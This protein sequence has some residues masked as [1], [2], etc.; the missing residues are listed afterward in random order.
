ME[1]LKARTYRSRRQNLIDRNNEYEFKYNSEN[2][3]KEISALVIRNLEHIHK[4]YLRWK[5]AKNS[6][7]INNLKDPESIWLHWLHFD[8]Q[9]YN[10]QLQG[11]PAR[12]SNDN[13]KLILKKIKSDEEFWTSVN[14]FEGINCIAWR[15]RFT[16]N[17]KVKLMK[18]PHQ[19][20]VSALHRII[21]YACGNLNMDKYDQNQKY[22]V[23]LKQGPCKNMIFF[24]GRLDDNAILLFCTEINRVP[25]T[26]DG[27]LTAFYHVHHMKVIDLCKNDEETWASIEKYLKK[28]KKFVDSYVEDVE[29]PSTYKKTTIESN[30]RKVGSSYLPFPEMKEYLND[31]QLKA[32]I[33][34]PSLKRWTISKDAKLEEINSYDK[35]LSL[36]QKLSSKDAGKSFVEILKTI[37]KFSLRLTHQQNKAIQRA[38]HVVILGR[39]GTGKTTS[40]VLR[41]FASEI[42][43]KYKIRPKVQPF[44][45]DDLK[46]TTPLHCIF[47]TASPVLTHEVKR[48]Y[49]KIKKHLSDELQ[50]R[51]N[52][53]KAAE[54]KFEVVGDDLDDLDEEGQGDFED[55][56]S[57]DDDNGPFSMKDLKDDEFPLFY[58]FRRL[59]MMID[60]SI[61]IPFFPRDVYGQIIG[62]GQNSDWTKEYLS[63]MK[64][65]KS[66]NQKYDLDSSTSSSDD[67]N[68]NES[69]ITEEIL[70]KFEKIKEHR[71]KKRN[72]EVD[73]KVFKE[74]FWPR[75]KLRTHLSPLVIWTEIN[76]YIKGSSIAWYYGGYLP[77][78]TYANRGHKIT[79]LSRDDLLKIWD[80]FYEYE[81]WKN[82]VGAYDFQDVI[83][84][85]LRSVKYNGYSGVP[86]HYM[87]ADEVQDLTHAS[88]TLLL[89]I[90]K[91]QIVFSGDTAQTIAKGSGF[92][93]SDLKNLFEE[94]HLNAPI[95]NQLTVNF[96]TH[97][98]VLGLANSVVSLLE[99]L[100]PQ[101]IDSMVRETSYRDG[102]MPLIVPSSNVE[103]LVK[104]V[105]GMD[106]KDKDEIQFGCNQVIIVRNQESKARIPAF[107]SHALCLTVFES[108]GLEFEDVILFNFFTDSELGLEK[109]KILQKIMKVEKLDDPADPLNY[110]NP[111]GPKPPI[112]INPSGP[113]NPSNPSDP[114]EPSNPSEPSKPTPAPVD[115]FKCRVDFDASK[116]SL[117]CTE[118]KQLYVSITR[119]KQNLIIFDENPEKR[120][121]IQELWDS[122]SL[123]EFA[124]L[125]KIK[126]N[127]IENFIKS[128]DLNSWKIQGDRMMAHK[129]YDQAS[130][131]FSVCGE[132]LLERKALAYYKAT[133]THDLLSKL[134]LRLNEIKSTVNKV[135]RKINKSKIIQKIFDA[136]KMFVDCAE[137]FLQI[138]EISKEKKLMKQAAQCFATGKEVLKAGELFEVLGLKGQAAECFWQAGE[139]GK[140][141]ELFDEKGDYVRGIECYSRIEEWDKLVHCLHRNKSRI[142][143]NELQKFVYKYMPVALEAV[144]PK[145]LPLETG[146][147]IKK[148]L[149]EQRDVIQEESD[150]D[151]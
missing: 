56:E 53:K 102:P 54:Q 35:S 109:W 110:L 33:F 38:G 114:S 123:I 108:K 74:K 83:N 90:C 75:I 58:T 64:I 121:Y 84:H 47:V 133:E 24:R 151:D 14:P 17:A 143:P 73:F 49:S 2:Q 100:F 69:M 60:A 113:S 37:P 141:G 67:E 79:F 57:D 51:I 118:L 8:I 65:S 129:F 88:I 29:M 98:Q 39:S 11:S 148:L 23:M 31:I 72:F 34:D 112:R 105:F 140:A 12:P 71:T 94:C 41:M 107:L 135:N 22:S 1:K 132:K 138:Y 21:F 80:F 95:I 7:F 103:D 27:K 85:I 81:K 61:R 89:S 136:E 4:L 125:E 32:I 97:N 134:K 146:V 20:K 40:A 77:K 82:S 25:I 124:E 45:P 63:S 115:K 9:S 59:V 52:R 120:R 150:E 46:R 96:R 10:S 99:G 42:L 62:S 87:M 5:I 68:Y 48:F 26:K 92:R 144:I 91:E 30:F 126:H 19:V 55:V 6:S 142:P 128:S 78:Y 122:L 36:I 101:T 119:P 145:A 130:K 127:K 93:F 139:F 104:L 117:L 70:N 147:Y 50:E 131:C 66:N 43:F 106:A 137:E 76:A 86:I 111:Y 18:Q 149:E 28:I 16:M 15:V 13:L 3:Q 44:G 116:H